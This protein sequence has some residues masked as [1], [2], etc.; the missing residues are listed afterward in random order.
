MTGLPDESPVALWLSVIPTPRVPKCAPKSVVPFSLISSQ[1]SSPRA[2][3]R[4]ADAPF[5]N[6]DAYRDSYRIS[7]GNV[8]F[9]RGAILLSRVIRDLLGAYRS[10]RAAE[11][12]TTPILE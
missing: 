4:A 10:A 11:K 9:F 5:S 12:A 2:C 1:R 8:Q 6:R 7:I 3:K